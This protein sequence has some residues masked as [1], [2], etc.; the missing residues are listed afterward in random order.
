VSTKESRIV[1][2]RNTLELTTIWVSETLL[3][4]IKGNSQL[5]IKSEPFELNFDSEGALEGEI[6]L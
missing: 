4:E 3:P 2:I 1:R 6:K 5:E